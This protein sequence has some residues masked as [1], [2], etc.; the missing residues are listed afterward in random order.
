MALFSQETDKVKSELFR[1]IDAAM[2]SARQ[3]E[4]PILSPNLYVK[5]R[6]LYR[7]ADA[8]YKKGERLGKIRKRI[9]EATAALKKAV[10]AAEVTKVALAEILRIRKESANRESAALA[11]NEFRKAEAKFKEAILKAEAGDIRSAKKKADEAMRAYREMTIA[12]LLKGPIK[13]AEDQ[14]KKDRAKLS[15]Q[16]YKTAERDLKT[17]KKS[18]Q[19]A[20]KQKFNPAEYDVKIRAQIKGITPAI[21]SRSR[22]ASTVKSTH[23]ESK[24]LPTQMKSKIKPHFIPEKIVKTIA[25]VQL[26]SGDFAKWSNVWKDSAPQ[27]L[28]FRW[29]TEYESVGSA[30]WQVTTDPVKGNVIASGNAGRP[31]DKGKV[32][33]FKID[34][35]DKK[36]VGNVKQRPMTYYVR[37][38]TYQAQRR[39]GAS[40]KKLKK[41]LGIP[42][43]PVRVTLIGPGEST[44][45]TLTGLHPELY[46]QMRISID[47]ETLK[48]KGSG[49]DEEP[50]LLIAVVYADGTTIVPFLDWTTI[51]PITKLP[52]EIH[53]PSSEVRIDSPTKTH[54]NVPGGDPGDK[55]LIPAATGHFEKVIKPIGMTL[56]GQLGLSWKQ[57]KKLREATQ[58]GILVIGF[59]EDAVPSTDVVNASREMF[60]T[61]LSEE[62]NT[63]IQGVTVD[64]DEPLEL[65]KLEDAVGDIRK[66]LKQELTDFAESEGIDE[67]LSKLAIPAWPMIISLG[68]GN[69][70]DYIGHARALFTY[71]QILEAG[72]QGIPFEMVLNQN[73]RPDDLSKYPYHIQRKWK[74]RGTIYYKIKGR[75]RL[76]LP[77]S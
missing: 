12:A 16:T 48:I 63:I 13:T 21:L 65:P 17:L 26:F 38:V 73:Y 50:F 5:A 27:Q 31:P 64:K 14:L 35:A 18:V 45:F 37:V 25:E 40:P 52:Q 68:G 24:T 57:R 42:S 32:S 6:E 22:S 55:L 8:E 44:Q 74:D 10:A 71:E 69:A 30:E 46:N 2:N 29:Q 66:K 62:L 20:K 1:E 49:Y 39:A 58:V 76:R 53:F 7:R 47:L 36:I 72:E 51:D 19:K 43:P 4:V 56:V 33:V 11:P 3:E 60:V 9:A 70:D 28:T 59:E 41:E 23:L 15:R 61:R 34:F 54:E 75:I 77:K 67:V